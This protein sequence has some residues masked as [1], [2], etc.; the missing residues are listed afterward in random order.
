MR[1]ELPARAAQLKARPPI[2]C[3]SAHESFAAGKGKW[4]RGPPLEL[5]HV[6][7]CCLS[8]LAMDAHEAG[9]SRLFDGGGMDKMFTSEIAR[10][11]ASGWSPSE[12]IAV[13]S[14]GLIAGLAVYFG[15]HL[16]RRN[17]RR[18]A[19]DEFAELRRQLENN[20]RT[21]EQVRVEV[22]PRDAP[23]RDWRAARAK[24]LEELLVAVNEADNWND[25]YFRH[26]LNNEDR[27]M[28]VNPIEM[29]LVLQLLY[30]HELERP[31]RVFAGRCAHYRELLQQLQV[32]N[33]SQDALTRAASLEQVWP[34][35]GARNEAVRHAK[36]MLQ[37]ACNVVMND[38]YSSQVSETQS[39]RAA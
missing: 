34:K 16:A 2:R 20:A 23:E 10:S 22:A 17:Q 37:Q 6:G 11:V 35:L 32:S 13:V 15:P 18:S 36:T 8:R 31:V 9:A 4:L 1:A 25:M 30:F 3:A 26:V 27:P 7:F 19:S 21:T 14:L 29:V 33:A 38:L 39:P 28:S 5:F 24:K 12:I